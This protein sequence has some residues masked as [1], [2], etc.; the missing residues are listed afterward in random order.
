M[1]ILLPLV[2]DR[3]YIEMPAGLSAWI[4]WLSWLVLLGALAY[5]W[6]TFSPEWQRREFAILAAMVLVAIFT[7]MIAGARLPAGSALPLPQRP[8]ESVG[9]A[10]LFLV[11]A[12][13]V[14]AA[15]F[16]GAFPAALIG[17]L[18]GILLA[19]FDTHSPFTPLEMATLGL[20]L[21]AMLRQRYRTLGFRWLRHPPVAALLLS[22]IY[23]LIYVVS[24]L[25]FLSDP[26]AARLDYALS[27][28]PMV[29]LAMAIQLL[30]G[31]LVGEVMLLVRMRG[32]GDERS[33]QPSPAERSLQARLIFTLGPLAAVLV[34]VLLLG[35]W[36]IAGQA[37]RRMLQ[38]RMSTAA[39]T[40]IDSIPFFLEA[41]QDLILQ[42]ASDPQL[43]DSTAFESQTLL[44]EHLRTVPFFNQ[45]YLLDGAG[46]LLSGYPATDFGAESAALDEIIG[47]QL[48]LQ[49]VRIQSYPI[50]P[51]ESSA[52]RISFLASVLDESGSPVRV[53]MG[54][55]ELDTNPFTRP[56]I[57]S[58]NSLAESGGQGYL[59]DENGLILYH[60]SP[61]LLLTEYAFPLDEAQPFSDLTAADGTRQLVY[62]QAAIGRPWRVAMWVP[63]QGAQEL[64][65]QI[66]AP[67]LGLVLILSLLAFGLVQVGLRV[68][69]RSLKTLAAEADRIAQGQLDHALAVEGI[70]EIGKL[71]RAFEEMR[72]KLK[73]RL[74]EL[75]RLLTVS[76]VVAASLDVE[77]A[78]RPILEAA[79]T[80]GADAA[81]LALLPG[82]LPEVEAGPK[83]APLR[84]GAGRL[85]DNLSYLDDQLLG[86]TREQGQI[87]LNNP[88]R[89][90]ALQIRGEHRPQAILAMALRHENIYY[91][92]LW[93]AYEK[94]HLFTDEEQRF[95]TTLATQASLAT[96]N[97]RLFMSA[98]IGRQRLEAILNSTADPVFVTDQRNQLLV[99]NPAGR[100]VLGSRTQVQPGAPLS[101]LS[102]SP[103]LLELL[104]GESD[105]QRTGE[106]SMPDERYYLASAAS[107][108]MND[109]RIGRVCVLRDI[110]HLK[111]LD[112]LKSE[113]V[114]TVSHDLRSP[115]T[116]I[117]GYAT[118]L[119][120]M[121]E[122]NEQQVGYVQ[123]I[124]SGIE[125]MS[126]LVNNLLDLGRIEAG[127]GLQLELVPLYDVIET[128]TSGLQLQATQKQIELRKALQPNTN[129]LIEAD[130]ALL[131]QAM[132][133]LVENAIKYTETGGKVEVGCEVRPESVVVWVRD[134]GIGIAPVD[135]TRLFEKFYRVAR[136]GQLQ[137]RGTG[138]GLAIVKS[139]AERHG[140]RVWVDSQLGR[141][142][143][144]SMLIPLRQ[145]KN[146]APEIVRQ[147]GSLQGKAENFK[148]N[149]S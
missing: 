13:L 34:V 12:P 128:V 132:H 10:V 67:L 109:Q 20:L 89:V 74:E 91:G 63:A 15:G 95:L 28:A 84:L 2:L 30:L 94:P 47:I 9:P 122:L 41:G 49:G 1:Q 108:K 6:R 31:A 53:L 126:R 27:S 81:R 147:T 133:N 82:V 102:D 24:T 120:M 57:A 77:I 40:A 4:F 139:I 130:Q 136:K 39:R 98:E 25:F 36:I 22:L 110:T 17:L 14:L 105:E 16:L 73:A 60:P 135:Q 29:S 35:D 5:R 56:I 149:A 141:G 113:F 72:Q 92:A 11:G 26:L 106:V 54:R 59:I 96:T 124:V 119:Q 42:I 46:N 38:D 3:P 143:L 80:S 50:T 117:R 51:G 83:A 101:V 43:L 85:S 112:A 100:R 48:A 61:E 64:A 111:E 75:S 19:F 146:G 144:F 55:V 21:G 118:M 18:S 79:L 123:K 33:P 62:T 76:Q 90:R 93:L 45:L 37:A 134:T 66:A 140:G 65:L 107:I 125:S 115:L 23:P 70:D 58:L 97:A 148:Q 78:V 69:T 8:V 129:P 116:L 104:S 103:R 138:L 44:A 127:V 114:S 68:I 32:W 131:Q 52:A 145:G 137:Q 7:S 87:L 71:R 142:S 86:L 88:A 121:G 99:I